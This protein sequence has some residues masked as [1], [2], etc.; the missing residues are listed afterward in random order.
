MTRLTTIG[1][2]RALTEFAEE[3]AADFT[4]NPEHA[5]YGSLEQGSLLA[6]RWGLGGDCV[7]VL[8]LDDDFE[9]VNFQQAVTAAR[10]D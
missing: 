8:K 5:S 2:E 10:K 4:K 9:R 7:L 1:Q 3:A 6:L